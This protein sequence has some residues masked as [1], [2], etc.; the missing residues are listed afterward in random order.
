MLRPEPCATP[1][2]DAQHNGR[3]MEAL[4][5]A[6]GHDPHHAAMPA[7]APQ[8]QRRIGCPSPASPRSA[9]KSPS[10]WRARPSGVPRFSANSSRAIRFASSR[11][12]VRNIRTAC[13]ALSMRPEALMAGAMR[14]P[15]S[16]ASGTRSA[17]PA[18]SRSARSPGLRTSPSPFS[19]CLTMMRFSPV[20]GTISATVAIATSFRND[21]STR[22]SFASGHPSASQNRVRQFERHARAA[23]I[24]IRVAAIRAIRIDHGERRRQL[25]LPAGGDP[26]RSHRRP[27]RWRAR[28]RRRRECRCPR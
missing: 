25:R 10:R 12:A 6:A 14:K 28:W 16:L 15:T 9:R 20:S 26:S 2:F 18:A 19:P 23:E 13:P 4:H 8:H 5:H 11:S 21:S 24:R 1:S 17:N 3:T 22:Y 7:L 27:V